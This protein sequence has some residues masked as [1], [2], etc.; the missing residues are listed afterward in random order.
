ME[1]LYFIW[2]GIASA[3]TFLV[4]G[5]DKMQSR[6]GGSRVPESVLHWLALVG[7]FIGGWAGRWVFRHKT[8]K[9]FFALILVLSTAIHAG[10]VYWLFIK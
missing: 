10:V 8:R 6:T 2:L 9:G 1:R 7:G 4:Y 3:I 5:V